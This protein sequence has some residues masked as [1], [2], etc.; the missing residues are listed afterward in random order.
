MSALKSKQEKE[1]PNHLMWIIGLLSLTVLLFLGRGLVWLIPSVI[2]P[3]LLITLIFWLWKKWAGNNATTTQ[4]IVSEI[5]T[6]IRNCDTQI[7]SQQRDLEEIRSTVQELQQQLNGA[8][9]LNQKSWVET[10]QLLTAF[11]E[12]EKIRLQKIDFFK[13]LKT[14]LNTLLYNQEAVEKLREKKSRLTQMRADHYEDLAEMESL[15]QSLA[16]DQKF[17]ETVQKLSLQMI[18]SKHLDKVETIRKE[19]DKIIEELS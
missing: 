4:G 3:G 14:N 6:K 13:T 10:Q 16:F 5:Q 9:E 8:Y 2:I 17:L 19:F 18:Q 15:K 1:G 7:L 11:E 12:E